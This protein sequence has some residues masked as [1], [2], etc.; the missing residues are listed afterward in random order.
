VEIAIYSAAG[1]YIGFLYGA[2]TGTLQMLR[3]GYASTVKLPLK[4]LALG[5]RGA[6]KA[7]GQVCSFYNSRGQAVSFL[8]QIA[9]IKL[10]F[11]GR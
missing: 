5:F 4:T 6:Y 11:K 10:L 7:S 9:L 3:W 8:A 2:T 1:A